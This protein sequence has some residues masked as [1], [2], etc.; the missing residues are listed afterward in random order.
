M[1]ELET[2]VTN[3]DGGIPPSALGSIQEARSMVAP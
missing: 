1:R 2:L 3:G